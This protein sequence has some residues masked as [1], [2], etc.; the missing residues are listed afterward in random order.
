MINKFSKDIEKIFK[1]NRLVKVKS[2]K[3]DLQDEKELFEKDVEYQIVNLE[4]CDKHVKV[5]DNAKSF[6]V[7]CPYCGVR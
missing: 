5:D 2:K 7:V 3:L 4:C 1:N 6:G